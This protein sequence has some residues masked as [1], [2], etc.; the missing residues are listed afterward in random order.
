VSAEPVVARMDGHAALPRRN[1]ELVF[2]Q[3][4]ESRAFGMVV[5]LHERGAFDW[6]DFRDR[7]VDEIGARPEDDGA[8][9]YE[10]WLAAF[11]RLLAERGVLDDA[12]VAARAREIAEHEHDHEH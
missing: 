8:L 11:E 10:R 1:G 4:W 6:D 2:E 7:L 5:A 9:Y 12:E 3:P